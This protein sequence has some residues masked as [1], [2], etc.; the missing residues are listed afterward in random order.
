MAYEIDWEELGANLFK[1]VDGETDYINV[2]L[3][4][5]V[6]FNGLFGFTTITDL[7]L[8]SQYIYCFSRFLD[9]FLEA[10]KKSI[11]KRALTPKDGEDG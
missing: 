5:R 9:G 4:V 3:T 1:E 8:E 2:D 7:T 10:F 6:A 11:M